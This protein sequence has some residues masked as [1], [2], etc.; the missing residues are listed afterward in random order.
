MQYCNIAKEVKIM[1]FPV[2]TADPPWSFK[3]WSEKGMN[4]SPDAHYSVLKLDDIK[5]MPV[6]DFAE[7]NCCLFLWVINSM[8]PQGLEVINAWGFKFKTIPFVYVKTNKDSSI[9]SGL[10]YWTRQNVELCLL[11]TKGK[12]KRKSKSV[13]QV[14]LTH[15]LKHSQKPNEIYDRIERLVDGPYLELFARKK[16]GGQ[17]SCWGDEVESDIEL[18]LSRCTVHP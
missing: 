14:I 18:S 3:V 9:F 2:I 17:W 15:R 16:R 8:L 1:K 6:Q 5:R 12:P 4:R 11:G 10:G 13:S 7:D